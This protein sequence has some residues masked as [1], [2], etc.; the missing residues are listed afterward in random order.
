MRPSDDSMLTS[1]PLTKRS[2]YGSTEA[3]TGKIAFR[4]EFGPTAAAA[5][6][7]SMAM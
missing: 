4:G 7:W 3:A 5:N 2:R 1:P 6:S